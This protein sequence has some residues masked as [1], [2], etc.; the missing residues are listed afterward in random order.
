MIVMGLGSGISILLKFT[1][2]VFPAYIGAIFAAT[3][4]RNIADVRNVTLP[5]SGINAIGKVFLNIFLS[6]TIMSLEIWKI[7][8][9]ALP[10]MVILLGQVVILVI[11][12]IFVVFNLLGKDY[13]S[14]VMSAGFYG[15]AMGVV[16][17]SVVS[18]TA[19]VDK[20]NRQ[21]PKAFFTVP[22]VGGFLI[23]L[24]LSLI[25]ITH[26]NLILSGIL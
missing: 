22:I 3:I 17:N 10:L 9:I 20:Y 12:T 5:L 19:V 21:S 16:P 14:A 1:G 24:F 8:S 7:S 2:L 11:F 15:Y 25:V 18:M 26:M 23:D 4:F 6:M 13:D